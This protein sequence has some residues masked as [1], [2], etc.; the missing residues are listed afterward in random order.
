MTT[1]ALSYES[2]GHS[3]YSHGFIRAYII[4]P[5]GKGSTQIGSISGRCDEMQIEQFHDEMCQEISSRIGARVRRF[6]GQYVKD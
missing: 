2:V 4:G 6:C 5:G 1:P 3:F